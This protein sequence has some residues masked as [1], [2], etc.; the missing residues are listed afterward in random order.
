VPDGAFYDQVKRLSEISGVNFR[1]GARS[2]YEKAGL[3]PAF[4]WAVFVPVVFVVVGKINK[5]NSA[6]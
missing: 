5:I 3:V 6:H 1:S 2:C 4:L